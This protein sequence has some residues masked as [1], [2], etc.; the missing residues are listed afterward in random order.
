M[1]AST[2]R[3]LAVPLAAFSACSR[4]RGAAAGAGATLRYAQ[5]GWVNTLDPARAGWT[6]ESR[7]IEQL[8]DG[9][10]EVDANL[11][12]RAAL[13]ESWQVGEGGRL[14]RFRLRSGVTLGEGEPLTSAVVAAA[15][16][17]L[18]APGDLV[19]WSVV[20]DIEG[21]SEYR[22]GSAD[23]IRGLETP[24]ART[25]VVRLASP[26]GRFLY[27][28]ATAS[29]VV[30][31]GP[32]SEQA[33]EAGGVPGS[34]PFRLE[35]RSSLHAGGP[36]RQRLVFRA[37][38]QASQPPR[39]QGMVWDL[40]PSPAELLQ[41]LQLE[42]YDVVLCSSPEEAP[43][44][45]ALP[46]HRQRQTLSLG[47]LGLYFDCQKAPL[48]RPEV[49]RALALAA[50]REALGSSDLLPGFQLPGT[51]GPFLQSA[52]LRRDPQAAAALAGRAGLDP[53]H[54]IKLRAAYSGGFE[55]GDLSG[56][57]RGALRRSLQ[58]IGVDLEAVEAPSAAALDARY[59][60]RLDHAYLFGS[61]PDTADPCLV[62]EPFRSRSAA[63]NWSRYSCPEVDQDYRTCA[64]SSDVA[65]Q[66]GAVAH[67][68]SLVAADAP[69][70]P[71]SRIRQR[72]F[73]GP[74]V[75]GFV[76]SPLEGVD[77][78]GVSLAQGP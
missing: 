39:V 65:S 38:P 76:P 7:A 75:E 56:W 2:L 12:S 19:G 36:L 61:F 40:Y 43:F 77:F 11:Q 22:A 78:T 73:L 34:G 14:Y 48:D 21:A 44:A 52:L 68:L 10:T 47:F 64:A 1:R 70:L 72:V 57:I 60:A 66:R 25:L 42:R 31:G 33:W 58:A 59:A 62:L 55:Y 23:R 4:D 54:A 67:A 63:F 49:R 15:L 74:G 30:F 3:W 27:Q 71:L 26:S 51:L 50:D 20:A 53:G 45:R 29:A 17:R 28:L 32:A 8:A 16:T 69:L 24:D 6:V 37:R 13:A 9:L 5:V 18:A 35:S 46:R 41:G